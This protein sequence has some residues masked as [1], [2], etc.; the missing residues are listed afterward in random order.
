MGLFKEEGQV[1]LT[2]ANRGTTLFPRACI[3]HP[4][5]LGGNSYCY[6]NNRKQ[7]LSGASSNNVN[8]GIQIKELLKNSNVKFAHSSASY[9]E[10]RRKVVLIFGDF[11]LKHCRYGLK[12]TVTL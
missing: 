12:T 5:G 7:V 11:A 8:N 1:G 10:P 2:V 9:S 6:S 3:Q 4:A